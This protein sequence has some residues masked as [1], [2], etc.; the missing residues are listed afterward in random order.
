[1]MGRKA[2]DGV[3]VSLMLVLCALW[4][5][6][7]VAIKVAAPSLNP[8][9]QIGIRSAVATV[10]L[11]VF[12]WG[13]GDRIWQRDATL[14]PG[15]LAGLAFAF[16]FLFVAWGLLYT[17][18]SHMV[19]FLYTT[20]IFTALGLHYFIPGE[21][22]SRIQWG[23]VFIAFT[24]LVCAFAGS[25]FVVTDDI[26]V[27]TMML[28]DMLGILAGLFWAATTVIIRA[29]VLSETSP[30][31]TMLY[32]L[33]MASIVLVTLGHFI[34]QTEAVVMTSIAWISLTYQSVLVGFV[35]LLVWF[36]LLRHYLASRL[37][38][39]S[40]MTPLFGVTF[41][42][43]LLD[44]PLDAGFIVGAVLVATGII[45]VNRKTHHHAGR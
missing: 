27:S 36:W 1:M 23:G 44:D 2:L 17:T 19:V 31:R 21:R 10:L 33:L 43:V 45:L 5:L 37:S 38:V 8:V 3:A 18:A 13:R 7:Q 20:P 9:L 28:G 40:F 6:Q 22:L 4:G 29:T 11:L 14:V 39:F 24:G 30:T 35:S 26:D 12:M 15:V 42:V 41:G 34:F 16:E 32:Q 25:L